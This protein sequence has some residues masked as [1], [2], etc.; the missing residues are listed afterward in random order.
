MR[1]GEPEGNTEGTVRG[2]KIKVSKRRYMLIQGERGVGNPQEEVNW[3]HILDS[4]CVP[5]HSTAT[6]PRN[7]VFPLV[8]QG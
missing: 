6:M 7:G 2:E 4:K 5:D 8:F 3:H 1:V